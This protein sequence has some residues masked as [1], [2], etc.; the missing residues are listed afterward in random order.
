VHWRRRKRHDSFS[1]IRIRQRRKWSGV[2]ERTRKFVGEN[3]GKGLK[4][5]ERNSNLC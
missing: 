5:R 1:K 4:R 3:E 2:G